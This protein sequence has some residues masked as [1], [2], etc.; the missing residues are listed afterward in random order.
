MLYFNGLYCV[1]LLIVKKTFIMRSSSLK[2]VF[3][4]SSS[5]P[6]EK[7][8]VCLQYIAYGQSSMISLK[9][10]LSPEDWNDKTKRVRKT[11]PNADSYNEIIFH[12]YCIA[13]RICLDYYLNPLKNNEYVKKLKE[14][15]QAK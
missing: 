4:K 1:Y 15:I 14:T 3:R 8:T 7:G 11:C 9:I 6:E 13:R 5:A 2:V 10:F 12:T